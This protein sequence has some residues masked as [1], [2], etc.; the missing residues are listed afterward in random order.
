MSL[1]VTPGVLADWAPA[2]VAV[3]NITPVARPT[4]A[5]SAMAR[6]PHVLGCCMVP[7][8]Q[9]PLSGHRVSISAPSRRVELDTHAARDVHDTMVRGGD[10]GT[11][12]SGRPGG[13]VRMAYSG[14]LRKGGVTA[15]ARSRRRES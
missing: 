11:G 8:G 9:D 6:R 14:P 10:H 2:P 7:P 5:S 3:L 15:S 13:V 1:A 4:P 12:C